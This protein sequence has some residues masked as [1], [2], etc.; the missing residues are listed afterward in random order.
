V[1]NGL[2]LRCPSSSQNDKERANAVFAGAVLIYRAL[3]AVHE[4]VDCLR[5][6]T[7]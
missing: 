3:P 5:E 1:A 7:R 6:I 4:L 2:D